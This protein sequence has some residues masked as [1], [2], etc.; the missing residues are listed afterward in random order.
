[1]IVHV[2]REKKIVIGSSGKRTD[3]CLVVWL[4]RASCCSHDRLLCLGHTARK[5]VAMMYYNTRHWWRAGALHR[6]SCTIMIIPVHCT[7]ITDGEYDVTHYYYYFFYPVITSPAVRALTIRP[8]FS[9]SRVFSSPSIT[10][11]LSLSGHRCRGLPRSRF[12]KKQVLVIITSAHDKFSIL[13]LLYNFSNSKFF[14]FSIL[15]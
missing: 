12:T 3:D 2:W 9:I 4:P 1:M 7:A 15:L 14:S 11:R 8:V 6:C 13:G 5:T 10:L